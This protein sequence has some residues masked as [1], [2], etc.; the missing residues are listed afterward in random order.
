MLVRPCFAQLGRSVRNI[1][2]PMSFDRVF[3]ITGIG[4]LTCHTSTRLA[5]D[6]VRTELQF[7]KE[8]SEGDLL[9]Q[10]SVQQLGHHSSPLFLV[11]PSTFA[12]PLLNPISYRPYT[13]SHISVFSSPP[14]SPKKDK[15]GMIFM[16]QRIK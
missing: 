8:T 11:L 10:L 4:P 5:G 13:Y 9:D 1:A 16:I 15:M 2:S 7:I 14:M 12:S 6:V 3:M